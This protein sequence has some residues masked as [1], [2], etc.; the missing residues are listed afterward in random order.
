LRVDVSGAYVVLLGVFRV[1]YI[2]FY[3]QW[4]GKFGLLVCEL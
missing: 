2:G 4:S 3:L 1:A